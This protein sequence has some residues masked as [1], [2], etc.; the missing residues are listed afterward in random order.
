M[1][2]YGTADSKVGAKVLIFVTTRLTALYLEQI[3][4]SARLGQQSNDLFKQGLVTTSLQAFLIRAFELVREE[5]LVH[6][7]SSSAISSA[8]LF[9]LVT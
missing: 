8:T 9:T 4:V 5:D 2:A 3:S 1:K 7:A 6:H